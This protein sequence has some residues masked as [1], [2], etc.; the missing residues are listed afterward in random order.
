MNVCW[1]STYLLL[2]SCQ[3]Y[4][5][6]IFNFHNERMNYEDCHVTDYYWN[7]ACKFLDFFKI[8]YEA[9]LACPLSMS[10]LHLKC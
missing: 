2:L 7:V 3:K 4:F 9:I 1:N 5:K 6:V 8:F 10:L